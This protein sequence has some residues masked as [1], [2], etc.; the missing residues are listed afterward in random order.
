M[1]HA[2]QQAVATAPHRFKVVACGRRW[3]KTELGKHLIVQA[4]LAGKVAWW[5][6]PTYKMSAQVWRDL[7]AHLRGITPK[8]LI[9]ESD[10]RIELANG[11]L[12]EIRS[13]YT[14]DTLR[15]AGLDYVVLDESA[16]MGERVWGEIVRPMLMTTHGQALFISSP[17]GRNWFW[18]LF[19]LGQDPSQTDWGAF[20]F[21]SQ[22]N[23][24]IPLEEFEAIQRVTPERIWREEYLAEFL[25]DDG[26]V[27]RQVFTH[28]TAS[29][30][31]SFDPTHRYVAGVD[32]GRKN[33]YTVIVV[34][35]ATTHQ[36]VAMDRFNEIGWEFQ[37]HRLKTL[38]EA[39]H[40]QAVWAE[41]NS[42]G[43]VNIEALQR[44]G[45][46]VTPFV[47]TAKSKPALIEGLSLAIER[48]DCTLQPLE[49]LLNE[50]TAYTV[51]RLS[52]GTYR[53]SAPPDLHDDCVIALA[54]AW[55]G[56]TL[57]RVW[58]EFA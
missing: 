43:S 2:G 6:A 31:P 16:F 17:N 38:C 44:E 13:T 26:Q 58:L 41:E 48:G 47:T 30:Q 39:W 14:P 11:G 19:L 23:P 54:L 3:G 46:P 10:R 27:F 35:D 20:H 22:D 56:A 33:D 12:L 42:I 32:W 24:L 29:L 9:H 52:T 51:T 21:T 36:M 57:P 7:K 53:Y 55:W 1:L 18:R 50:L 4:V 37:R 8:P 15:G 49:V 5:L 34:L 40:V 25:A 28:A 45:V